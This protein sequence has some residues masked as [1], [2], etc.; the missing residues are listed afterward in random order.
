[1]T[2]VGQEYDKDVVF[3]STLEY[4]TLNITRVFQIYM[5]GNFNGTFIIL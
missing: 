2:T 3:P 4:A 5:G 1:M